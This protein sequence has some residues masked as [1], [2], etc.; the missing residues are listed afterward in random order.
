MNNAGI[1]Y[2]RSYIGNSVGGD[3]F[4]AIVTQANGV[5]GMWDS[6]GEGEEGNRVGMDRLSRSLCKTT[7]RLSRKPFTPRRKPDITHMT[8]QVRDDLSEIRTT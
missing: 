2:V 5:R 1:T 8:S 7:S 6:K 4:S 3:W